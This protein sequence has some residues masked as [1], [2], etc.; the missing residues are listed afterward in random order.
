MTINSIIV[1]IM[2]QTNVKELR[3]DIFSNTCSRWFQGLAEAIEN[4]KNLE[5]LR[6]E[7]LS[8]EQ[9]TKDNE[10]AFAQFLAALKKNKTL[11]IVELDGFHPF[12][13]PDEWIERDVR[14]ESEED[15]RY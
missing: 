1:G 11:K 15:S 6:I 3:I 13:V 9:P 14:D 7:N 2:T 8:D 12:G 4:N 5:V 10:S